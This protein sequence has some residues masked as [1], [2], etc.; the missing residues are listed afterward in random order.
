MSKYDDRMDGIE[1][2]RRKRRPPR[3]VFIHT[4]APHV[5]L[6]PGVPR[7]TTPKIEKGDKVIRIIHQFYSAI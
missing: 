5:K 1:K 4:Y 3:T 2:R 6:P 7:T